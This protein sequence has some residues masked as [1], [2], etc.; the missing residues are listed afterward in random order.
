MAIRRGESFTTL[1]LTA[2]AWPLAAFLLFSREPSRLLHPQLWAEDGVLWL[3]GGYISG[4]SCLT[5]P[6]AGYLQTLSRLTGLVAA[7]LPMTLTPL[8]FAG[9]SFLFQLLPVLLLLSS[10]G[11][12]W[13]PSL[14]FRLLM[15]LY[16]IGE[17]NSSEVY[18]NLTNAMWHLA[19]VAFL[20]VVMPKP[21]SRIGLAVDIALLLLS[22]VSGPLVLF[23][24][25]VAWWH[26]LVQRRKLSALYAAVLSLGGVAQGAVIV[27]HMVGGR[28]TNLGATISRLAH[29]LADQVFLGGVLGE[30]LVLRLMG[31]SWWMQSWPALLCCGLAFAAIARVFL[32]GPV[33]YRQFVVFSALIVVAALKSPMISDTVP[34]WLPMQSPGIAGRYFAI[35]ILA[36]FVTLV[37]L[38]ADSGWWR[39]LARLAMA[40]CLAGIVADWRYAP[41]VDTGYYQQAEIFD[42][43]P[44]GTVVILR[45]NPIPWQFQL[46]KH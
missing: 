26:W 3:Q 39:W 8:L 6:V 43:A 24:A 20:L 37:L 1:V 25:P 28:F 4:F 17:P 44:S 35:P 46:T 19:L 10:R 14:T 16:Y 42:R 33:S 41:Y 38:A 2:M 21:A 12:R 5:A 45:E 23:L 22:G 32:K 7:Q 29:I 18:V 30:H 34:Q 9:V 31:Q 11:R 15:V 27:T 40:G 13:L 36:W